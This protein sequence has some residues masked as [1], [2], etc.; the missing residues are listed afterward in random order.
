MEDSTVYPEPEV[1]VSSFE[2]IMHLFMSPSAFTP[3]QIK[4][5]Y[6]V[7]NYEHGDFVRFEVAE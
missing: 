7:K 1:T 4:E 3:A 6:T 5:L 2:D